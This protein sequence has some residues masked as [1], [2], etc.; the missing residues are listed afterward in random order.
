M[1]SPKSINTNWCSSCAGWKM[2]FCDHLI[3]FLLHF[4]LDFVCSDYL[5]KF[6]HL[7]SL[8]FDFVC[9]DRLL[10]WHLFTP[11]TLSIY[12]GRFNC[13]NFDL[14]L[15]PI[16]WPALLSA[17]IS[18]YKYFAYKVSSHKPLAHLNG[19]QFAKKILRCCWKQVWAA[20]A[21]KALLNRR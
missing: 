1:P 5:H 9:S 7:L 4:Q 13:P 20:D 19:N 2:A 3:S 14:S 8:I 18:L 15:F 6:I 16:W 17:S 21:Q 12:S 10:T 11:P